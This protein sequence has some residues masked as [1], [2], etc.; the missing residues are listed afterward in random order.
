MVARLRN[1]RT[2]K[3][4][5]FR[6]FSLNFDRNL[7]YASQIS[8]LSESLVNDRYFQLAQNFL[9]LLR[10]LREK[11]GQIADWSTPTSPQM[12]TIAPK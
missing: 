9:N 12:G 1:F 2:P 11:V 8:K 6:V 4:T 5:S 7:S 10:E 3:M